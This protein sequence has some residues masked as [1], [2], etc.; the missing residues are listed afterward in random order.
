[1][2]AR[3]R[4]LR[5]IE[6]EAEA[7]PAPQPPSKLQQLR[8]LWEFA[9]LHQYIHIFGDAVKI[10]QDIDIDVPLPP[11]TCPTS[12]LTLPSFSRKNVSN[13]PPPNACPK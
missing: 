11:S 8:N 1:M 13:P 7:P 9:C 4:A 2:P 6:P 12:L 5:D 3:K 10:S